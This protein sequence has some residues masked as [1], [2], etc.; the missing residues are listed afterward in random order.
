MFESIIPAAIGP[1]IGG[2]F[3]A[4]GA[5]KQN[6]RAQA[7]SQEMMNFQERMSSTAYQRS[8]ADMKKAGLNPILAY[9]QGG[10]SSPSGSTYTPQNELAG[11]GQAFGQATS[12]ALS[13]WQTGADTA[14]KGA[15]LDSE[16]ARRT[17]LIG[18][19]ALNM[20]KQ[21]L[22]HV[23][24]DLGVATKKQIEA[25]TDKVRAELD[26][27]EA[28]LTTEE[29]VQGIKELDIEKA[30]ADLPRMI[31]TGEVYTGDRGFYLVAAEIVS[32]VLAQSGVSSVFR[33]VDDINQLRNPNDTTTTTR[34]DNQ[35][36]VSQST[37]TRRRSRR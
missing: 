4:L 3:S 21:N 23:Q 22:N 12:S 6:D 10:A 1:L 5:S 37:T 8:M 27:T 17:L 36:R 25:M 15:Q 2:A 30:K 31:A 13:A 33:L 20:S 11:L 14:L 16:Q 9:Q 29:L 34:R 24:A 28:Q 26:L 7:A 19:D 32:R 35:G 18:Q